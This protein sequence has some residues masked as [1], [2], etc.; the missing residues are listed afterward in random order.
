MRKWFKDTDGVRTLWKDP[1]S[2]ET[3]SFEFTLPVDQNC[4]NVEIQS[5]TLSVDDGRLSIVSDSLSNNILRVQVSGEGDMVINLTM[6][7]SDFL[8]TTVRFKERDR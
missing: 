4:N 2:T 1:D 6:D 7:N 8:P 3:H 5:Y